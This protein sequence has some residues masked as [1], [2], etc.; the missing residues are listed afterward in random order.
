[1]LKAVVDAERPTR[2]VATTSSPPHIL[3][4]AREGGLGSLSR[5]RLRSGNGIGANGS[6]V[7]T[8]RPRSAGKLKSVAAAAAEVAK[9]CF[10]RGTAS[11]F[12]EI[13]GVSPPFIYIFELIL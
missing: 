9:V 8:D 6:V 2:Q 12:R 10:V 4:G 5:P 1:M 7:M 13:S 3:G 11:S